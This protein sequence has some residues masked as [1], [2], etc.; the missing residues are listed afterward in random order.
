[1]VHGTGAARLRE[2]AAQSVR[3]ALYLATGLATGLTWLVVSSAL[4]VTG[5][6][7]LPL[8]VG[9]VP[10]ARYS[11]RAYLWVWSSASGYVCSPGNGTGSAE[12]AT[13][14]PPPP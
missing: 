8:L 10:S 4:L 1:M 13:S 11:S 6:A 7:T 12:G 2:R 5:V 9:V 14:S 3:A